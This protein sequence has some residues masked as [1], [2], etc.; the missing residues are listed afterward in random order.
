M[1]A[2][3]FGFD[4][5][6]LHI[7]LIATE[8]NWNVLTHS[9]QILVP[10]RYTSVRDSRCD[11]KHNDRAPPVNVVPIAKTSCRM[12]K[13]FPYS[14]ALSIC[15]DIA[16]ARGPTLGCRLSN[17]LTQLLLS[18]SV[19]R[20][21]TDF[22]VVSIEVHG[23]HIRSNGRNVLLFKLPGK[24][25]FHKGGLADSSISN[26]DQF[27]FSSQRN[28]QISRAILT[29]CVRTSPCHVPQPVSRDGNAT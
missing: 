29:C 24:V 11:I 4:L 19:P 10:G 21:K 14:T 18:C 20:I 15:A 2:N 3:L 17:P 8:H 7:K 23:M 12:V 13:E 16:H 25:A 9:N 28:L 27:E 1:K 26:Y 22:P 5:T 6:V